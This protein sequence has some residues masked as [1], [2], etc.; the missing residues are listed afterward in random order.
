MQSVVAKTPALS[1]PEGVALRRLLLSN[2]WEE[3]VSGE[4]PP[5]TRSETK[6]LELDPFE[7]TNLANAVDIFA[8]L[9][10]PISSR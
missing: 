6:S 9:G 2:G 10:S 7:K 1:S 4:L 5:N 8:R 3:G